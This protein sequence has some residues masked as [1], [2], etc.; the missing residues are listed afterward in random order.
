MRFVLFF[1]RIALNLVVPACSV[2]PLAEPILLPCKPQKVEGASPN[3]WLFRTN[4]QRQQ[5]Q[6]ESRAA[7]NEVHRHS[8]HQFL[9]HN[10]ASIPP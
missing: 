3:K 1:N 4:K 6:A 2:A 10:A 7:E 9:P 5:L 8:R